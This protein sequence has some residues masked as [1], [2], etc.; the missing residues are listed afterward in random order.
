MQHLIGLTRRLK[1]VGEALAEDRVWKDA[2]KLRRLL[3][4]KL[5]LTLLNHTDLRWS[6][7]MIPLG[8]AVTHEPRRQ[9]LARTPTL[10]RLALPPACAPHGGGQHALPTPSHTLCLEYIL[11]ALDARRPVDQ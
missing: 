11:H 1:E 8:G 10:R 3:P 9:R 6:E 2:L 7:V 5:V 4:P